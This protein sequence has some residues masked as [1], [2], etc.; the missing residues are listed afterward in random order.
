MVLAPIFHGNTFI[1]IHV[2]AWKWVFCAL[3]PPQRGAG[4]SADPKSCLAPCPQ[5]RLLWLK[6]GERGGRGMGRGQRFCPTSR[7][8]AHEAAPSAAA[9]PDFPAQLDRGHL[10]RGSGPGGTWWG[11]GQPVGGWDRPLGTLTLP[12]AAPSPRSPQPLLAFILSQLLGPGSEQG[13]ERI[14]TVLGAMGGL[15]GPV[16]LPPATCQG[17]TSGA[18]TETGP[19]PWHRA[20]PGPIAQKPKAPNV[21]L[22]VIWWDVPLVGCFFGVFLPRVLIWG[23]TQPFRP[24]EQKQQGV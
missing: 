3:R 20:A 18:G 10:Q 16:C 6:G 9:R 24:W 2:C 5:I 4:G 22:A 11:R 14:E 13:E 12:P 15:W 19:G 7:A 23:G 1:T 8:P 21:C 17:A